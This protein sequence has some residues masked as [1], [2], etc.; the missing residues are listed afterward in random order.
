[1]VK[2]T[3]PFVLA[4]LSLWMISCDGNRVFESYSGFETQKW[5]IT[6]TVSFEITDT[7]A[8]TN[9]LI[10]VKYNT[11]YG[12]RNLYVKYFLFDS[13]GSQIE[14][15]LVNIPLFDSQGGKPLGDGF[16]S[17]FTKTDTLPII[18]DAVYTKVQFVQYMRVEELDGLEAIGFKQVRK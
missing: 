6:D 2:K 4:L 17:T 7:E 8:Y 15:Q 3:F 11:D 14:S 16:G 1:M 9:A 10:N 5:N 18:T 12:F 13:L